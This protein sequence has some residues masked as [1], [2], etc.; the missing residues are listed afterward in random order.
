MASLKRSSQTAI[1][2]LLYALGKHFAKLWKYDKISALH[3]T[4]KPMVL[5]SA[6]TNL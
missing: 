4:C 5:A 2:A 6:Q 1:P 3:I